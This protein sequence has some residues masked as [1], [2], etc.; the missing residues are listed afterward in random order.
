MIFPK[1]RLRLTRLPAGRAGPPP[2]SPLWRNM[3]RLLLL[4]LL[5]LPISAMAQG[6]T[7]VTVLSRTNRQGTHISSS[8]DVPNGTTGTVKFIADIAPNDL[9]DP[10]NTLTF[11][12][13]QFDPGNGTWGV[14]AGFT[15]QGGPPTKFGGQ[16]GMSFNLDQVAGRTVRISLSIPVRMSI[17]AI[18]EVI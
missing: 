17:G 6:G 9:T 11:S 1:P 7:S 13:E 12:I 18:I 8:F 14:I 3:K 16:P 10:G 4:L 2:G 15:W 5:L